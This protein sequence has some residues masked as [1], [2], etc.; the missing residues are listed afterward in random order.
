M[1]TELLILLI[2]FALPILVYFCVKFG[3]VA[4][5]KA[6]VFMEKEHKQ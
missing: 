3:T 5:Y 4:Y 1:K 2:I 6:K